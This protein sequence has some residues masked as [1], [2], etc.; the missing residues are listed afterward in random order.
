MLALFK[1]NINSVKYILFTKFACPFFHRMT[2]AKTF[3]ES[4]N[5]SKFS[6]S[7]R[8]AHKQMLTRKNY[9]LAVYRL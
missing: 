5:S 4:Y 7:R 3:T 1:T 8:D 6:H 9:I 2:K